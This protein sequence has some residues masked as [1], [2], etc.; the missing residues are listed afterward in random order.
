METIKLIILI[1]FVVVFISFCTIFTIL[2]YNFYRDFPE[3]NEFIH[4]E[5][6]YLNI[7][8]IKR[9]IGGYDNLRTCYYIDIISIDNSIATL[10]F[11]DEHE[12][13][14][15]YNEIENCISCYHIG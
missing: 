2:F 7:N 14:L 3:P 10:R 11:N 5:D 13:K 9:I 15:T 12:Y 1:L 6:K 8:C 4:I